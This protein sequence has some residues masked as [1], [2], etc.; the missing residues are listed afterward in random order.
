MRFAKAT[1][2]LASLT[3]L[4]SAAPA[5]STVLSPSPSSCTTIYPTIARVDESLPEASYLPGFHVS[6]NSSGSG[7]QD[8]FVEFSVPEGVWGCTLS[9]YFPA[10]E[11]VHRIGKGA[12]APAVEVFSV[13]APGPLSRT[14]R[15]IDISWDNCPA[16]K[17]LVGSVQFE[18]S[19]WQ[20]TSRVV[21]SFA[22]D[23]TMT[24]RLSVSEGQMGRAGVEFV[25]SEEAGLRM[26][27]NC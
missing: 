10:G 1:A 21:N 14:S 16:K 2:L 23:S 15:G 19:P 5:S 13:T 26:S 25:Q 7:K 22:C 20:A 3:S 4:V 24:Y 18:S 12:A 11:P 17:S 9:Y 27:Y 8:V 6:Q